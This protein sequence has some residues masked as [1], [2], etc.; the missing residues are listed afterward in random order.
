MTFR[1]AIVRSDWVLEAWKNRDVIDFM[2]TDDEFSGLHKVRSFEGQHVC[3]FGFEPDEQEH[4]TGIL[5]LNGGILTDIDDPECS[6]VVS[7]VGLCV[8]VCV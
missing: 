8:C 4:M 1:L 7:C 5:E 3:F 2:A 6:H